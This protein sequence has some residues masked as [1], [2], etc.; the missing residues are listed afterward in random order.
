M[1]QSTAFIWLG[2]LGL[3]VLEVI[4]NLKSIGEMEVQLLY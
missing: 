3:I 2:I 4:N 1:L